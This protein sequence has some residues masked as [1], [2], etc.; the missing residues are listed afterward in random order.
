VSH[1]TFEPRYLKVDFIDTFSVMSGRN[2]DRFVPDVHDMSQT[3]NCLPVIAKS[4]QCGICGEQSG[5]GKG[6]ISPS[7]SVF[8]CQYHSTIAL[9]SLLSKLYK[10][11]TDLGGRTF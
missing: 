10:L 7:T 9:Y 6:V 3:V 5:T 2:E 1:P 8:P 4:G 11:G